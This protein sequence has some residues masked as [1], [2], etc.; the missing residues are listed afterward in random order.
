MLF[1]FCLYLRSTIVIIGSI[2]RIEKN[3]T[4]AIVAYRAARFLLLFSCSIVPPAIG[5]RESSE[6]DV[7]CT[8]DPGSVGA[9]S[10]GFGTF[11]QSLLINNI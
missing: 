5:V 1:V 3:T 8:T 2:M 9:L 4:M 7:G 11:R 10:P 6:E